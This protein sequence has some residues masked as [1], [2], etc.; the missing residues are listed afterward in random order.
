MLLLIDYADAADAIT[1]ATRYFRR[2]SFSRFDA[3]TRAIRRYAAILMMIDD[4][5]D[6]AR[7]ATAAFQRA[8]C[9]DATRAL[10]PAR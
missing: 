5:S 9:Y 2:V 3:D 6:D 1:R 10:M 4:A 7:D 8:R